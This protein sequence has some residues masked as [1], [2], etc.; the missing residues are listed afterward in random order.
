M[1][2]FK[3]LLGAEIQVIPFNVRVTPVNADLTA[4]LDYYPWCSGD[5]LSVLSTRF[6]QRNNS[7]AVYQQLAAQSL[8]LQLLHVKRV[9]G[10]G[11]VIAGRIAR[12]LLP[13][14]KG[15]HLIGETGGI[16]RA[17]QS[18]TVEPGHHVTDIRSL[19]RSGVEVTSAGPG[20]C[21][22]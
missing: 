1:P 16:L 19:Q 17:G 15:C 2:L 20:I 10:V 9:R 8:H 5:I 12:K 7:S 6:G 11:A 22:I 18:V 13:F 21:H 3:E 4:T 14:M